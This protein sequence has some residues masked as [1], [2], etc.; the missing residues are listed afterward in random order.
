MRE[1]T[2]RGEQTLAEHPL[3]PALGRTQTVS[4]GWA[5]LQFLS[6]SRVTRRSKVTVTDN[7]SEP[8]L[9]RLGKGDNHGSSRPAVEGR[10]L[11]SARLSTVTGSS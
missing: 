6:L 2:Q 4:A 10:R 3:A 8:Q 7:L 11:E 5:A 1:E 9:P